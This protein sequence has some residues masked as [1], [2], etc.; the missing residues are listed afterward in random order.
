MNHRGFQPSEI[1]HGD[2]ILGGATQL[3]GEVLQPTG[4]WAEYLP[5]IE[6]QSRTGFEPNA[7]VSYAILNAVETLIRKKFL[8]NV[9]LSDRFLAYATGTKEKGGNDP[10]TVCKF[11][12]KKGDVNEIDWPYPTPASDFYKPPPQNLYT[13]ALEFPAHYAYDNQW[14]PATPDAMMDALTRSPLTVAGYAWAQNADGLYYW[15]NGAEAVHYFLIYG[16]ELNNCWLAFDTYANEYKKL[17]WNYPFIQVK[18]HSLSNQVVYPTFWNRFVMLLRQILGLDGDSL[19]AIRS[20]GWAADSRGAIKAAGGL[21]QFGLHKPSL[22]NPLN[23]HHIKSF[24]EHPELERQPSN[25]IVLCRLHHW[26]H[27]HYKNWK[28]S[29]PSIAEEAKAFTEEL[30]NHK[31]S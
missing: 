3:K 14:V 27:A 2:Y 4:Q 6:D 11:L 7:C 24:H 17:V 10:T 21:C 26:I 30:T 12:G 22:F 15:P 18:E 5:Q 19:G 20:A 9:N 13:L 31:K 1:V 8:T 25:W 16:Y 23:T 29:N 28:D